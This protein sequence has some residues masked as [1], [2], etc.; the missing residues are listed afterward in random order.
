LKASGWHHAFLVDKMAE[1]YSNL[2]DFK[3]LRYL[4]VQIT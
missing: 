3:V 1:S 4:S 2:S